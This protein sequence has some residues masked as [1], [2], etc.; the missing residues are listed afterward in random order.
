MLKSPSFVGARFDPLTPVPGHARGASGWA[1]EG[2][3]CAERGDVLGA[4]QCFQQSLEID[5]DC[6]SAWMGLSEVF[7]KMN[8]G[9]RATNCLE[10]ARQLR[11]RTAPP[12]TVSA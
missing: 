2:R 6:Y 7:A 8:D 3:V 9:W 11:V 5:I 10:V 12:R 1:D 4:L